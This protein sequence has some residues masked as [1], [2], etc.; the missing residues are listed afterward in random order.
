MSIISI[1]D[2]SSAAG[3]AAGLSFL[4]YFCNI[5]RMNFFAEESKPVSTS[6]I[7]TSELLLWV[8]GGRW[9]VS[10]FLAS[11]V[12]PSATEAFHPSSS[13]TVESGQ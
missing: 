2:V 12:K 9:E 13:A 11:Q 5:D 6:Q 10:P 7:R 3:V 1:T 4:E 8:G